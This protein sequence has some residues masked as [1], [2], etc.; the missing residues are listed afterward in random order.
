VTNES[1]AT[2]E[3]VPGTEEGPSV[4]Q[5]RSATL[6]CESCRASTAH[7][8]LRWDRRSA[9]GRRRGT[10]TARCR[11]CGWTHAFDLALPHEVPITVIGSEGPTSERSIVRLSSAVELT[12]GGTLPYSNSE[13]RI[14]RI[15]RHDRR[16]VDR[17]RAAEIGTVWVVPN[18][19][20][21]VPVSI[22][23][24]AHTRP[25][26]WTPT[27]DVDVGVG[28][29]IRVEGRSLEVVALRA[30]GRTWRREGDRFRAAELQ[31]IYGRRTVSPP[32]GRS[33][34][35][36]VRASPRSRESSFSRSARSRSGPGV[37]RNR[38]APRARTAAGGAT[39]HSEDPS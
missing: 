38:R 21:A 4:G 29:Q 20:R 6:Y 25:A 19:P 15:D 8:I 30:R 37:S 33:D 39:V 36:R 1:P 14:R 34:W 26:R 7:R 9:A 31:R 3:S 24:G 27:S 18:R 32:A 22:L 13:Q 5:L 2:S 16:S 10:G 23:E 11:V 28:S 12:V 35:S 17:A